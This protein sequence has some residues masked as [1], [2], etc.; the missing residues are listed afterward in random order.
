MTIEGRNAVNELSYMILDVIENMRLLQPSSNVQVSKQSPNKF[1]KRTLK[2]LKTG[3]GQ[4]SIF[5]ADAIV[6]ELTR[7]GKSMIDA[8]NGG[9]SGCV[10]SGAFGMEAYI[11]TGYFNL[12]KILEIT[13]HNGF[14]PRTKKQIGITTGDPR[15]FRSYEDLFQAFSKQVRHFIDIKIKGNLIIE[16]LWAENLPSPFMSILVKDCIKNGVDYN[17]GGARY[18]TS[19][20]QIVGVGTITDCLSAL[21]MHLFEQKTLTM[22]EMLNGLDTNFTESPDIREILIKKSP[23]YGNDNDFADSLLKD[24][25]DLVFNAID[26]RPNIRGGQ[27]RINLLPTIVHVYFGKVT[28]ATPDGR[29]AM[30]PLSEGISP[31]QGMDLKGP[32]AVIRSAG[33][34]DHLRTGGTLLNQKFTPDLLNED[35][36][37]EKIIHLI[38]SYFKMDAHHVQFNVVSAETLLDAQKHPDQY[39]NLIV[40]VAGYSD[41]FVNLGKDLQ[42]E[43]IHRTEHRSL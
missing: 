40:R 33:K 43:I 25:F 39:R 7:Q 42:D 31:V 38:R 1:L 22:D 6:Q 4:P 34:I 30:T 12:V 11:L 26:G 23:K 2:I 20:I 29:L 35:I 16:K 36:A 13:L 17:A 5:N 21:K 19:Y 3:F 24:V 9:A 14:D 27:H 37:I 15:L 32:T 18:N 41:Y 10:E 28:G 8:R